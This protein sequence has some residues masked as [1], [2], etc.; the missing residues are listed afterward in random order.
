MEP[1]KAIIEVYRC[2][3]DWHPYPWR[4]AVTYQGVRHVFAGLPNQCETKR[5]A[6]IRA[7]YRA[8]WLEDGSYSK[9]Y[10]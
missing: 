1:E 6:S 2:K 9:R 5:A 10:Q 4:F 7:R 3:E 8:K